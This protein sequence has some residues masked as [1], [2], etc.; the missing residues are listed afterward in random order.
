MTVERA[1]W[2]FSVIFMA[3]VAACASSTNPNSET[4][5][6]PVKVQA[7]GE[8]CSAQK[9]APDEFERGCE[10]GE[11]TDCSCLIDLYL[12]SLSTPEMVDH[13]FSAG[14][15]RLINKW[16]AKAR[17]DY[18]DACDGGDGA[19]CGNAFGMWLVKEFNS[20]SEST[21]LRY[22]E[23]GCELNDAKSC[24]FLGSAWK[25]GYPAVPQRDENKSSEAFEKACDLGH[26]ESCSLLKSD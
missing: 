10:E 13:E 17:E 12:L 18:A 3:L 6:A 26:E 20:Y 2:R 16:W 22:M 19:A 1:K 11:K 7:V 15:V 9:R 8:R 14:T 21:A 24:F 5:P 25:S 4:V 23:K